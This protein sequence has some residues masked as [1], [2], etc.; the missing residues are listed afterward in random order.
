[1]DYD[2]IR[3]GLQQAVPFNGYLGL[4]VLEV[5]DGFGVVR[6]PEGE[7]LRNHVGSQ[8]AGALFSVAEA[9]SG[10]AM[11][12]AF[13]DHIRTVTPLVKS[14]EIRYQKIALGPITASARLAEPPG[15]VLERVQRE[16]RSE[17]RVQVDLADASGTK[18]AE[19]VVSWVAR[20]VG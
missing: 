10:V 4:E 5:G 11:V 9:A 3:S 1:V 20:R 16:G 13:A 18:V 12:G 6:L 17:F 14:A 2:A 8:H 15:A 19:V 7:H